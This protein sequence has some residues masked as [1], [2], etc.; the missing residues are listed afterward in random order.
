MKDKQRLNYNLQDLLELA[1]VCEKFWAAR[2][3]L[4][5]NKVVNITAAKKDMYN[6]MAELWSPIY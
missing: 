3:A 1:E 5:D 4:Y 6:K 2:R